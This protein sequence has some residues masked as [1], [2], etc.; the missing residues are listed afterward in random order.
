MSFGLATLQVRDEMKVFYSQDF[1]KEKV[2]AVDK[3]SPQG[4]LPTEEEAGRLI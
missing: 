3:F 1:K 2:I 4:R